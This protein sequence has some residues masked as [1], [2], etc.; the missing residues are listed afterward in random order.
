MAGVW[1]DVREMV[2][3]QVNYRELLYQMTRRQTLWSPDW[4]FVP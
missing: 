1:A 3:E 4:L 2:H